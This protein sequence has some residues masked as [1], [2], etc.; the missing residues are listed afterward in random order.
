MAIGLVYDAVFLE[1][2]MYNCPEQP[3]RLRAI[4]A[5]LDAIGLTSHVDRLAAR[6]ATLDELHS[7]HSPSLV[8]LIRS[9]SDSG[10]S[11]LD[12]DTY[13]SAGSFRA[14]KYAAGSA[15]RAV[16]AVCTNELQQVFVLSRPPGHHATARRA[17]G[18]CLF[19]NVAIAARAALARGWV[20]KLAIIDFDVHHGNGTANSFS[21]EPRILYIS[22][23]Q[24]PLY[25]GTGDWRE[26]GVNHGRGTTLNI[27]LPP[28]TGDTGYRRVFD[29]LVKPAVYRFRPEL[30]LISAGFDAH[31]A[32]PLA[33][34]LVSVSFYGE[35]AAKLADWANEL[36]QGRLV[37]C[38]EGGYHLEAL[39]GGVAATF[40]AL[41]KLPYHDSLGPSRTH[42]DD[43]GDLPLRIAR[44]HQLDR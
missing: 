29:E 10:G 35:L 8:N 40:S 13:I 2:D 1:H 30:L 4:M 22:T 17:M 23:H 16:E 25:P 28:R 20:K 39:A 18:F 15:I 21:E 9:L 41:L 37:Y 33:D 12:S 24:W 19:N 7:N 6:A 42:E 11:E 14:A 31:W 27:P 38:L 36:C 43:L 5:H 44:F 34:M 26:T 3:E 32:D